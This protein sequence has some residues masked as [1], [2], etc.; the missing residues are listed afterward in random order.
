MVLRCWTTAKPSTATCR[1]NSLPIK[2]EEAAA[3]AERRGESV[4]MEKGITFRVFSLHEPE[5]LLSCRG[6]LYRR[7]C[8]RFGLQ[9]GS[10]QEDNTAAQSS[11]VLNRG[12]RTVSMVVSPLLL[13]PLKGI[14]MP[15]SPFLSKRRCTSKPS[16][17]TC[18][19]LVF[20]I[21]SRLTEDLCEDR[22][23]CLIHQTT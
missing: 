16:A 9:G 5:L 2:W 10:R 18:L 12:Y 17:S 6:R 22:N 8:E 15:S 13:Q 1:S 14:L 11:A 21:T 23:R 19:V 3:E 20:L 4:G 7:Y